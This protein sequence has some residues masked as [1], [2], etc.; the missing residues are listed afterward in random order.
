MITYSEVMMQA[1][2]Q[3]LAHFDHSEARYYMRELCEN[4]NIDLYAN[5]D[6]FIDEKIHQTFQDGIKR[7]L[8]HEPVAHILGYSWF[9][10]RK[11]KVNEDVLIPRPETEQLVMNSLLEM[12]DYF[13]TFEL[14]VLDLACGSGAIGISLKLEEPQLNVSISDISID[15]LS[16]ARD[17]A[18]DLFANVSISKSDM[19]TKFII[20]EK[21]F[22]VIVCNPPY[23]LNNEQLQASVYDF[24]PHVALFGGEDGLDFYRQVLNESKETLKTPGMLAFEMG[25]DQKETLSAEILKVYPNAEIKHFKDYADL[26][27]MIFIFV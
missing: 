3:L 20:K 23:I 14:D 10:G 1:D 5:L 7:M 11:F 12:E 19:L 27:R 16:V 4:A 6:N 24:E 13:N 21:Q 22:D 17:N 8:N 15:A 9:Y 18:K 25:Y 2:R 26:D